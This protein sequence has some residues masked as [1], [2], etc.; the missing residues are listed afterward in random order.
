VDEDDKKAIAR[1]VKDV[2]KAL[3]MWSIRR[4]LAVAFTGAAVLLVAA[5]YL[6]SWMLGSPPR[7]KAKPMD[8][9]AQLDLLKLVFALVAGIGA[10]VALVT[11]YRRQRIEEIAGERAERI[12]AHAERVAQDNVHDAIE[13]RVTDLYGKAVEQLGHD[14]AAVRLGGLYAL[15]RLAQDQARHRQ[16]VV[17]VVC[18]YLRMPFQYSVPTTI[19]PPQESPETSES[20][21][22]DVNEGDPRQELQV[23]LTAQ[24]LLA[25]HLQTWP[26]P[27]EDGASTH[28]D[29]YWEGIELDL[30]GAHLINFD[31]ARCQPHSVN[32][33]GARFSGDAGFGETR[34]AGDAWFGGARFSGKAGFVET[35]FSGDARFDG[36]RFSGEAGFGEAHFGGL[37][38]FDGA[39]FDG[40]AGFGGARF[41]GNAGFGEAHFGGLAWFDGAR[42]DGEAG[43][44]KAHFR[45]E[46]WF[47]GARFSGE[48]GF[49]GA[50]FSGARFSGIVGFGGAQFSGDAEF[51]EVRFSGNAG[52]G[53]TQFG[54][55]AEFDGA[56][57]GGYAKFDRA[58]FSGVAGFG[59]IQFGGNATFDQARFSGNAWF[60]E[61]QFN[62][63]AEFGGARFSG[64]ARFDQAQFGGDAR[65]EET[66]FSGDA[67]FDDVSF[68]KIPRFAGATSCLPNDRHQWPF[69]WQTGAPTPDQDMVPLIQSH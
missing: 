25:R 24:R 59:G 29:S 47:D 3:G 49:G 6:V 58:R 22:T 68:D 4:A 10:L 33:E 39:R 56:Q 11:A 62:V 21:P 46:A 55:N 34:F 32:F 17:D 61:T 18:A 48:A 66:Q 8:T 52:F 63:N 60:G 53:K 64:E 9:S 36:V 43:F 37:A 1:A 19:T 50:W 16:T 12:Q 38:W 30:T 42:F 35:R 15:E 41:D 40:D 51:G 23:R 69:G 65:F 26:F 27:A 54:G 14:K 2:H 20:P 13:R 57:F 67:R 44:G 28:P 7:A 5:W 31:F 45:R